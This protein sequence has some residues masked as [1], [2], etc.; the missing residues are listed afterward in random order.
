MDIIRG[1]YSSLT[2]GEPYRLNVDDESCRFENVQQQPGK[3]R[4]SFGYSVSDCIAGANL[5]YRLIEA[6]RE[7]KGSSHEFQQAMTE[8]GSLQQMFLTVGQM[9]ASPSLDIATINAASVI[10]LSSMELIGNFLER[11]KAYRKRLSNDSAPAGVSNSWQKIGWA[12]FKRQELESLRD[13]LHNKLNH[14]NLLLSAA[15]LYAYQIT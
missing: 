10:V 6:L 1:A 2:A 7:T 9:R 5:T 3:A 8:L 4:M 15:N 13:V 14:L 12:L 11:T